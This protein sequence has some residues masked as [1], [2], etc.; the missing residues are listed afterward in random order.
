MTDKQ[1]YKICKKYGRKCLDA[2]RRFAGLL[3]EVLRRNLYEK[4]GFGSIYEFAAK[5]AGMTRDQV[6]IILRLDRRLADKPEL[7]Q[8]LV[9]GQIGASKLI[10]IASVATAENQ[11]DLFE[12]AQKLSK[13]ALDVFVKEMR[14]ENADPEIIGA[15]VA[16]GEISDGYAGA[17]NR[18]P[19][20]LFERFFDDISL[21]GQRTMTANDNYE[22][23]A[24]LSPEVKAK[25]K[26]LI[27]KNIDVNTLLM[28][29]FM[30]R[31]RRIEDRKGAIA[32]ELENN[33]DMACV[34]DGQAGDENNG[35][36]VGRPA[37]RHIPAVVERLLCEEF[38]DK[39]AVVG[40]NAKSE[41][42]HHKLG[43]AKTKS[44]DP[45][46]LKPLCRAHHEIEHIDDARYQMFRRGMGP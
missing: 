40:C 9:Q 38:G 6:D 33:K 36:I 21:P 23:L 5:L 45:R 24:A 7:H 19:D 17:I 26:D 1:L 28:D 41:N 30:E 32:K 29:F 22:I 34:L 4:K 13:N 3:P 20:G 31:E 39:C 37:S 46:H 44:H 8:A 11:R 14:K 12:T 35:V 27:D 15:G 25:L 16:D 43:F 18:D 42:I 2:R 10:W